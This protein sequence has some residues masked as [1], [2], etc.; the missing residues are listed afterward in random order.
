MPKC[1]DCGEEMVGTAR[2]TL[3]SIIDE[4]N[5]YFPDTHPSEVVI[6]IEVRGSKI[7]LTPGK[8]KG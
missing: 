6:K 5:K 3:Q 2:V 4:A 1:T 8:E 7:I